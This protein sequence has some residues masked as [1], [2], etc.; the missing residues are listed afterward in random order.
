MGRWWLSV[1]S[2]LFSGPPSPTAGLNRWDG[3]GKPAETWPGKA[4]NW[5]PGL[6][7]LGVREVGQSLCFLHQVTEPVFCT[8]LEVE[9]KVRRDAEVAVSPLP[10][11]WEG[12]EGRTLRASSWRLTWSRLCALT[13]WLHLSF[14]SS[15]H[16]T[17]DHLLDL[18]PMIAEQKE[19]SHLREPSS[20]REEA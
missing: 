3:L 19:T 10:P 4:W 9:V 2:S 15:F 11:G 6:C 13:G 5:G 17:E 7:G 1:P 20:Q 16:L 8:S 18:T 14:I 12:A